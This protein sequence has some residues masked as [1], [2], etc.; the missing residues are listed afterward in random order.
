MSVEKP[1]ADMKFEG[2]RR[3]PKVLVSILNWNRAGRTVECLESLQQEVID[4]GADVTVLVIDNGSAQADYAIVEE[5]SSRYRE[6]GA[7]VSHGT[8]MAS[9]SRY[10][11]TLAPWHPG[12]TA[13]KPTVVGR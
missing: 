4:S 10:T 7:T 8:C 6:R 2:V 5:A 12:V 13:S 9:S 11:G 1:D 3:S